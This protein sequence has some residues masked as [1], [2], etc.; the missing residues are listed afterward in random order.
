MDLD[1]RKKAVEA[2]A[3]VVNAARVRLKGYQDQD[4]DQR[5]TYASD[6]ISDLF[7]YLTAIWRLT[8]VQ[9]L[10]H[11]ATENLDAVSAGEF[12]EVRKMLHAAFGAPGDWGY[13]TPLGKALQQ[14]YAL[15]LD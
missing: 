7:I 8:G 2:V 15:G 6:A 13:S 14:L 5:R 10:L 11:E 9:L 4:A 3:A 12:I 1:T